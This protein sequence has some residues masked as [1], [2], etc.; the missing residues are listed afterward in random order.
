MQKWQS[1]EA[2]KIYDAKQPVITLDHNVQD[3]GE[4]N[5]R[6]YRLI[7]DFAKQHGLTF[8]PA[9]RGI[10]HQVRSLSRDPSHNAMKVL[11]F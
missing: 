2:T 6:K 8:F 5:L 10:G 1:L 3:K 9:G 11:T 7:E 4:V